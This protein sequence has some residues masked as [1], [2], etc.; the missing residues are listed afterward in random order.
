LGQ[1]AEIL[2]LSASSELRRWFETNPLYH[3]VV[4]RVNEIDASDRES[5]V[6][7]QRDLNQ[8][9]L[10]GHVLTRTRKR[11]VQ[12]KAKRIA[13]VVRPEFSPAERAFYDAVTDFVVS[14][15]EKTSPGT[16][17]R[18]IA[19]MPQRQVASC[20]PAMRDYYTEQFGAYG[21]RFDEDLAEELEDFGGGTGLEDLPETVNTEELQP[22]LAL[23]RGHDLIGTDTKFDAFIKLLKELDSEEPGRKIL[24]F[25]YFRRTLEY[26]SKRLNELGY[27]NVVISGAYPPEDRNESIDKFRKSDALRVLLSSEVGSEGLDF[28]FCH[29]M[30]N[31]DLPWNPMV[32]EQRIG[33]LDRMGQKSDRILIYNFSVPG[34]IEDRILNRLYNRIGIF[35]ESIGD[36]E[37][38]LGEEM[39]QLTRDLLR[40]KLTP[41][42]QEKRIDEACE[43]IIR[44]RKELE[45]L[46]S[47]SSKF[48]GG[49]EFFLEEIDRI[50]KNKRFIEAQ[51]L[52]VFVKEFLTKHHPRCL[53]SPTKEK[54]VFMLSVT[55]ELVNFIRQ[56]MPPNDFAFHKCLRSMMK[57]KV[58]LT[59]EGEKAFDD[60]DLEYVNIHHPLV[61][62]IVGYY[63]YKPDELHPVARIQ[64]KSD[65]VPAGDYLYFLYLLEAKGA[66]SYHDI[67]S[68]FVSAVD[69]N[70]LTKDTGEALVSEMVTLGT[71]LDA[72]PQP[73][74]STIKQL[75]NYVNDVLGSRIQALKNE[76]QKTNEAMIASR[77]T[78]LEQS[79]EIKLQKKQKLLDMAVAK[80]SAGQYIRMLEGGLRNLQADYNRRKKDIEDRRTIQLSFQEL[81]AG[82]LRVTP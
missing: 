7:L 38:I 33:R 41:E 59:F 19:V 57:D 1:V 43:I 44:K 24:L 34:T 37:P 32:V 29:I 22:L 73:P 2:E 78:S 60:P 10:L 12:L 54:G 72:F 23:L 9:N 47:N 64:M 53:L 74:K 8:L 80:Q 66:R 68:V 31:Y 4:R 55:Q 42:E 28:Q 17:G 21:I 70:V 71:T 14:R 30:V 36:L 6:D 51:E 16:F 67:E 49:D 13:S 27:P 15:Y 81:G 82:Y 45:V 25:S 77:L 3:D 75:I 5:V 69:G 56:Y 20:I 50:K 52:E 65:M 39:K 40:S 61:R 35:E 46:E 62:S 26:L 18:F 76:M 63:R 79:L 48:I 11:D 58:S